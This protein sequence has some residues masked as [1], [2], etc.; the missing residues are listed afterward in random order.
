LLYLLSGVKGMY[1]SD[2]EGL[3]EGIHV[4]FWKYGFG[5]Q[6]GIGSNE[7]CVFVTLR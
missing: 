6:N 3:E 1:V 2:K 7:S 4:G 5:E